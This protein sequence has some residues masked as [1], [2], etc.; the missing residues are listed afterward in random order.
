MDYLASK[1]VMHGDLACRNILLAADNVVKICDFGLAKDIYKTDN[2]RKKTDGPLPVKW[3]AIESLRDRVFSTQSDVWSFGIVLWEM[4]SLG[5]TPYPGIDPGSSFYDML[6]N[7]Y[8]MEKPGN[9]PMVIYRTM[10]ECWAAEP[11]QRPLFNALMDRLGDLLE[12]GERDH[13]L[14]LSK[15]FDNTIGRAVGAASSA[16]NKQYL[17][18]MLAPDFNTQMSVSADGNC[19]GAAAVVQLP[20]EEGYLVPSLPTVP[21]SPPVSALP[22][23]ETGYLIPKFNTAAAAESV[24]KDSSPP[25]YEEEKATEEEKVPMLLNGEQQGEAPV[26]KLANGKASALPPEQQ[27]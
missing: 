20:E 9:C 5:K 13:Y 17:E 24:A 1:K 26:P 6:L 15:R 12:D 8:R 11:S 27:V 4:F 7:G 10:L 14:D 23:D 3:M 2:Y 16:E 25:P 22:A 18:S 19:N 21:E